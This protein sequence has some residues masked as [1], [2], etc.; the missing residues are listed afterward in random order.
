M[1]KRSKGEPS[2]GRM[3]LLV[4]KQQQKHQHQHHHHFNDAGINPSPSRPFST[5]LRHHR[6]CPCRCENKIAAACHGNGGK[7]ALL[8]AALSSASENDTT[9]DKSSPSSLEW[10]LLVSFFR[11]ILSAI[12]CS[13]NTN[14]G[15]SLEK[16]IVEGQR[17]FSNKAA[18]DDDVSMSIVMIIMMGL[19]RSD[20]SLLVL[21]VSRIVQ[22]R[23][24]RGARKSPKNCQS[25]SFDSSPRRS[26]LC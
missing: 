18:S 25:P 4:S 21:A 10:Q 15:T 12:C 22:R 17:D 16:V 23:A 3:T 8:L 20:R 5:A 13:C 9:N 7:A 11:S 2:S 1:V 24:P 14:S 19:L 26:S 6:R